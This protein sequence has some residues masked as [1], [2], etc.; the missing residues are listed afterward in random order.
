LW[1]Y[2][3]ACLAAAAVT[4]ILILAIDPYDT[5]RFSLIDGYGVPAFGQRLTAASLARA[6]D[7]EAAIIGNSTIQ[8]LDPARLL[9]QTGWHFV[10]LAM[11]LSGPPEQLPVARWLIRHHDGKSAPPL[12]AL[13]IGLDK[14]WCQ[15][16][17]KL[18]ELE[19]FPS[20]LYSND[21]ID[22]VSAMFN[23][24]GVDAA[25]HKIKVVLGLEPPLRADGYR[26]LELLLAG[27]GPKVA[28]DLNK[29]V[30]PVD[31]AGPPDFAA[32]PLLRDLLR[33]A[34]NTTIVVLVFVPH[35][36]SDFPMPGT[37]AERRLDL[38]KGAYRDIAAERER[39]VVLDYLKDDEMTNDRRNFW[40]RGHYRMPIA[41]LI[42]KD[43]SAAML[44]VAGADPR[45]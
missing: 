3:V 36:I 34:P 41:K 45:H 4:L 8:L 31:A 6:P 42:E 10:S 14:T 27:D 25:V 15:S 26:N 21:A 12:K 5:G 43:I 28:A 1:L 13:I 39:T 40:D 32:V 35:F 11:T 22:Y 19:P 44:K 37:P 9:E 17:G 38:C 23:M 24:R 2:P 30:R 7:T 20:W 16:D 18:D 33:S 29:G